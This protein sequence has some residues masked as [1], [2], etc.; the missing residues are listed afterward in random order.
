M[1]DLIVS[2]PFLRGSKRFRRNDPAPT[3]LDKPTLN[4]YLRLGLLVR[5]E[6]KPVGP[7][8][9]QDRAEPKRRETPGPRTTK[10]AGPA[11]GGAAAAA[12]SNSAPA[13]DA[14]ANGD[15]AAAGSAVVDP[16]AAASAAPPADGDPAATGD[17]A[18]SV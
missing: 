7:V 16:A 14:P 6:N 15:L 5:A 3:D 1:S 2:K 12:A 10:P 13:A 17:G 9:R 8:R 18:G 11:D 4:E